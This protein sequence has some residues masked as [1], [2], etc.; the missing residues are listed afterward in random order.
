[1]EWRHAKY[2][3]DKISSFLY[4]KYKQT[5]RIPWAD[6]NTKKTGSSDTTTPGG[7]LVVPVG[8]RG[9]AG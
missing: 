5:R 7:G 4:T 8:E 9:S 3:L 6:R 1:M 2:R